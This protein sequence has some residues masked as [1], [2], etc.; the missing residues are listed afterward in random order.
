MSS[1]SRFRCPKCFRRRTI[2]KNWMKATLSRQ[3]VVKKIKKKVAV[4]VFR[5][6]SGAITLLNISRL[7]ESVFTK[8][9]KSCV[10]EISKQTVKICGGR[11]VECFLSSAA[12]LQLSLLPPSGPLV[13]RAGC[14]AR[15]R[16]LDI[17]ER[18]CLARRWRRAAMAGLKGARLRQ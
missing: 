7:D 14:S 18:S 16:P 5:V 9:Q 1:V 15:R 2:C 12:E 17:P 8:H 6:R 3:R 13:A 11:G 4:S 10:L